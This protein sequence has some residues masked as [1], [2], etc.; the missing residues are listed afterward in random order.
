LPARESRLLLTNNPQVCSFT[1]SATPDSTLATKQPRLNTGHR[2]PWTKTSASRH[3]G[4]NT[5]H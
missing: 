1:A 5:G 2:L 4:L 3:L